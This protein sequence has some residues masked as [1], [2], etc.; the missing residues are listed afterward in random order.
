MMTTEARDARFTMAAIQQPSAFWDRDAGTDRA[1][2]HIATA[3]RRGVDVVCFG[4]SWLPGYPFFAH[5]LPSEL[6]LEAGE[7]YLANAILI[8]GPETEALCAAASEHEVDVVIGVAELDPATAGSI[9]CTL[10][11]IGREGRILGRHRKLRATYSE[12]LVWSDGDA[13]GLIAH[14]RSY[15]RL[16][17]LNCW[18]HQML[19]PTYALA[20]Q[21]TE[22]HVAAWPGWEPESWTEGITMREEFWPRMHLLSRA[23]ASQ[24]ATYVVAVA[25]MWRPKDV[26]KRFRPLMTRPRTGDSI[27]VSP[28]GRIIAGPLHGRPGIVVGRGSH[29]DIRRAKSQVDI[30]GHYSRPDIFSLDW[31]ASLRA[32]TK[33]SVAPDVPGRETAPENS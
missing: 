20:A 10:L 21:G 9:Y 22:I 11:F 19:L 23:Y 32:P 15:A 25:G 7:G 4:E 12:R 8:P 28:S 30:A 29:A 17:G 33:A 2:T 14:Q 6:A 3:A 26:P 18:E 16:S 24:A 13:V 1:L 27:I 5:A 31:D